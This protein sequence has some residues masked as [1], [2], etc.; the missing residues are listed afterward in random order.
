MLHIFYFIIIPMLLLFFLFY[1]RRRK[2]IFIQV[3][4]KLGKLRLRFKLNSVPPKLAQKGLQT[5]RVAALPTT[6]AYAG[7]S[8][9]K[10]NNEGRSHTRSLRRWTGVK[11]HPF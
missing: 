10:R 4:P 6:L 2:C 9:D 7:L 1:R 3:S 5:T 11:N 8:M